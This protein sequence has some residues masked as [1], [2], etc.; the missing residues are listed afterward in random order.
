MSKGDD[1]VETG[2]AHMIVVKAIYTHAIREVIK[3]N[4]LSP[5]EPNQEA[6]HDTPNT[7]RTK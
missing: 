5:A 3:A 6:S 1:D 2:I 7:R 4:D